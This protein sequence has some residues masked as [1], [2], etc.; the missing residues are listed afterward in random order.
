MKTKIRD[1]ESKDFKWVE[2]LMQNALEDYY[3]GDHRAHAKRILNAH[4]SG[5]I[6]YLGF[7]SF[8]QRM[9]VIEVDEIRG[10]IIHIVGNDSQHTKLA[11]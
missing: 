7:F 11:P 1:A 3:G 6:D 2:N 4:L 9:F 8:E 5:G 10:G